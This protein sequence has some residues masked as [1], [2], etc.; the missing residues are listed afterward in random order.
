MPIS[1]R[2]GYPVD[3]WQGLMPVAFPQ[4][5]ALFAIGPWSST[6]LFFREFLRGSR[7]SAHSAFAVCSGGLR[8]ETRIGA[9][10]NNFNANAA[11]CSEYK[12]RRGSPLLDSSATRRWR[13]EKFILRGHVAGGGFGKIHRPRENMQRK[14]C[15]IL[16]HGNN[17]DFAKYPPDDRS[18]R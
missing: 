15:H 9:G 12:T 6:G 10:C 13:R 16:L 1:R 3:P 18:F 4:R 8:C 14:R 5:A 11:A 7:H 2:T 17:R